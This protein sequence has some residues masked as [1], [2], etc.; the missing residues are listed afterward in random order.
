MKDLDGKLMI[1][2]KSHHTTCFPCLFHLHCSP[3]PLYFFLQYIKINYILF[4][5]YGLAKLLSWKLWHQLA[6]M[7]P[8][9]LSI[10]R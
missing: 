9:D 3:F 2:E 7:P 1:T 8:G 10:V 6:H 4:V 5:S